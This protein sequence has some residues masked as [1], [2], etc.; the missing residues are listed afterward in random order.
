MSILSKLFGGKNDSFITIGTQKWMAKNLNVEKFRDGDPIPEA[1]T[2]ELWQK[3]WLEGKPA[4]C[5]YENNH[6]QGAVYGKLYNWYAVNDPRG[7]APSGWH[8]PSDEEWKLLEIAL[9]MSQDMANKDGFRG[10]DEG[11]K[12]KEKGII[13][14]KNPNEGVTNKSGFTALPGGRRISTG[15]FGDKGSSAF[16]WSSSMND[17]HGAWGRWLNYDYMGVLR[18]PFDKGY[19]ISVRCIK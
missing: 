9:G 4:W 12:L 15:V 1:K 16:F 2:D 17:K 11:V 13:H 10:K 14:W 5:F 8:I 3:A 6:E 18:Y 7:L 19:G